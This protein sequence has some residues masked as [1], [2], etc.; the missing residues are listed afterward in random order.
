M[1]LRALILTAALAATPVAAQT[2]T[3]SPAATPSS[4]GAGDPHTPSAQ[5][6]DPTLG[7]GQT[8]GRGA[9]ASSGS[10]KAKAHRAKAKSTSSASPGMS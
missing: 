1:I 5:I 6:Q 3:T 7:S 2:H 10:T 9:G 4:A 8:A